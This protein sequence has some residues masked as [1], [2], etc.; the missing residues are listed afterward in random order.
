MDGIQKSKDQPFSKVLF[1]V[2]IRFVGETTAVK[3][4]SYF[5][6]IAALKK[7]TYEELQN[8][9]DVGEK[10]ALALGQFLEVESNRVF[11]EKLENAGLKMETET[12]NILQEGN[13]L[14]G[15]TLLYTGTFEGFSREEIEQK[16]AANGGKLVSGVSKKLDFLIVGS[17]PGPSKITKA[18]TL[19][20]K[21]ISEEAFVEM[22]G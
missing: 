4:A 7:A 10:V 17:S 15:K 1:G 3:L 21:M 11:L 20:V 5:Q 12:N 2:G 13:A 18:E 9:P 22:I 19:G 8:V 16:I 6:N 14:E